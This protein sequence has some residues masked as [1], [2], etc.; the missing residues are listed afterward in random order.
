V[1]AEVGRFAA[2]GLGDAAEAGV[3][4]VVLA[5]AVAVASVAQAL[6]A[7]PTEQGAGEVVGVL[8]GAVAAGAVSVE[9]VLDLLE[10]LAVDDRLVT[11]LALDAV[12][13]D[14]PD[15]A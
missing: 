15:V 7:D 4:L 11:S 3:V 14:D 1:Q 6:A 9:D 13:G 5:C 10:G 2:S 8:V 12:S